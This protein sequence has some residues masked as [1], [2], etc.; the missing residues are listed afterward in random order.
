MMLDGKPLPSMF[1]VRDPADHRHLKQPVA[2]TFALSSMRQLEPLVDECTDIFIDAMAKQSPAP[3]DFGAWLQWYAFDV[4][5]S[6]TFLKRF[7]F[8]EQGKDVSSMIGNIGAGLVYLSAI[9][10]LPELHPWLLGSDRLMKVLS[11]IPAIRK[12]DPFPNILGVSSQLATSITILKCAPRLREAKSKHTTKSRGTTP[13]GIC[14]PG[15]ASSERRTKHE[16]VTE[17]S[18]II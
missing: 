14:F 1:S 11:I 5:G 10:Y 8:M 9:A 7:G 12:R 6:I 2:G 17:T 15:Y 18:L 16:W 3:V 4:I 13:E